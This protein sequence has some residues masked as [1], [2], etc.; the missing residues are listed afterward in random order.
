M[1]NKYQKTLEVLKKHGQEH[2]LRFYDELN[3][4]EKDSL[5]EQINAVDRSLLTLKKEESAAVH[6]R[7]EP[8][9]AMTLGEIDKR[10]DEFERAGIE[11]LKDGKIAAV[12]LAGGQGT[13]L[14]WN[15]PKGTYNIGITHELYIFE[16]LIN[17]MLDT[18]KA[19]GRFFPLCIMTSD[20]NNDETTEFLKAHNFFGYDPS[21]VF[22]FKQDMAPSIDFNGKLYLEDKG[23]LSLSPNGNGGWFNS[24][25]SAGLLDMLKSEGI[26]WISIFAVDNVLQRI[27][28]PAFVGAT[29]L[30]GAVCGAKV[31]RKNAP[32]E[33]IGVLCLED[34]SPSIVEYYETTE[35]MRVAKDEN[36]EPLYPFGVTLNYLYSVAEL[37]RISEKPLKYHI[38]EK[39]IPYID[40]NGV[41]IDPDKPNGIKFEKLAVD[42][43]HMM[44]NCLP[45]EIVREREFAPIK[46]RT[47]IDSVESARELLKLN[48][49]KL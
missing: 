22:F 36:G 19:C 38:V 14:G 13:R 42:L 20:K 35:E 1:D 48:G 23:R 15:G 24:L 27:N 5:L 45:Y 37:E 43:I 31:I 4:I 25:K 6:G 29:L 2:L 18:V 46:N 49:V 11:A 8:L 10:R 40:E 9:G 16:C 41:C 12:L 34:G 30:S 47:G 17:N 39:K 44:S 32:D 28:D 21:K 26:E 3:D 7:I 33:R